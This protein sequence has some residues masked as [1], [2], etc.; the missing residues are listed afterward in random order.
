MSRKFIILSGMR[1]DAILS[2]FLFNLAIDWIMAQSLKNDNLGVV[3]D[4]MIVADL[5]LM[6]DIF[7]LDDNSDDVQRLLDKVTRNSARVG[8]HLNVAKTKFCMQDIGQKFTVYNEEIERVDRFGYLGYKIQLNGSVSSEI[9]SCV[10]KASGS[11][12]LLNKLWNQHSIP[13]KVKV[14]IY[15]ICVRSVVLYG[16]ESWPLK[17]SD[18]KSLESVEKRCLLRILHRGQDLTNNNIFP[19]AKMETCAVTIQICR[20]RWL[21]HVLRMKEDAIPNAALE[22]K[23]VATGDIPQAEPKNVEKDCQRRTKEP[24]QATQN[25]L[26]SVG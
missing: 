17:D 12:K 4:D 14:K 13:Q 5:D 1:Q 26:E 15:Q 8:L 23:K 11:F 6:D 16:C 9:K 19:T 10:G 3:L 18:L 7:L 22:F 20:L 25:D 21:G 2:L 24:R